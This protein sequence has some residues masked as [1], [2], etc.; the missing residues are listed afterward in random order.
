MQDLVV[1]RSVRLPRGRELLQGSWV[2]A[3]DNVDRPFQ[4]EGRGG[5]LLAEQVRAE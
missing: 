5:K 2:E 4:T 1:E 3:Q